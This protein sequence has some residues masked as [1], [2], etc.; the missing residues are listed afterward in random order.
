[1]RI[2][3]V[4]TLLALG[5]FGAEGLAQTYR[6]RHE[7]GTDFEKFKTFAWLEGTKVRDE[8][9]HAYIVQFI[10]DAWLPRRIGG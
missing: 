6:V 7:R 4:S 10:T 3:L 2:S 8:A 5:L 9:S 1:M